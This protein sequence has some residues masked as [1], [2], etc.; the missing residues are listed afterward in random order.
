VYWARNKRGPIYITSLI[1]YA[2]AVAV[3]WATD[4]K[5]MFVLSMAYLSVGFIMMLITFAWK[6]SAHTASTAGMATALWLVLGKWMLPIYVFAVL[7]IWARVR[8]GAHTISQA[9]AGAI[10]SIV[11]TALVFV[12]LYL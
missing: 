12:G 7:M 5:I 1:A 2:L 4:N 9:L 11:I 6:I 10:L 8:M 3:F